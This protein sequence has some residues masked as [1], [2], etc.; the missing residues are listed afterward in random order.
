MKLLVILPRVPY[1]L[2]KG[3]KL[4][5]YNQIRFLSKTNEI[6]LCALNDTKLHPNAKSELKPYC[7]RLY[8]LNISKWS[9]IL[10][11]FKALFKGIPFQVGYFYNRKAKQQIQQ[12]I[13]EVQPDHIYCQLIR[14]AEYVKNNSTPKTI[15]YQD[16]FFKRCRTAYCHFT[17]LSK[18]TVTNGI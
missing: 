14:V 17:I 5:A 2:E 18:A 1:P 3:D 10:N 8:I 12:I 16:V 13:N 15:D 11:L 6:T 4:R 9:I 7:K